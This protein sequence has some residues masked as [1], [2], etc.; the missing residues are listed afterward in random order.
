MA[1]NE[2]QALQYAH[3]GIDI[4]EKQ[5]KPNR[6]EF[7]R[8]MVRVKQL[9]QGYLSVGSVTD[10]TAVPAIQPNQALPE[11]D[12]AT[13]FERK[14]RYTKYGHMFR[15]DRDMTRA[16]VYKLLGDVLPKLKD[17]DRKRVEIQ[18]AGLMNFATGGDPN[19][20]TPDGLPIASSLHIVQGGVASN[21][22]AGNPVLSAAAVQQAIVE[23]MKVPTYT[24][25][26]M[27]I[28]GMVDLWVPPEL[29]PL[30]V[31]IKKTL[32]DVG[33]N[34]NDFNFA[35]S[36]IRNIVPSPYFTNS[37][38]WAVV[39][40]DVENPFLFLER[41]PL[42]TDTWEAKEFAEN[43]ASVTHAHGLAI[44]DWRAIRFS[45]GLGG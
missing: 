10:F 43:R 11:V 17:S 23:F 19:L 41:A 42:R 5:Y 34:N 18:V 20:V 14:Y 28:A 7:W 16:D 3:E 33:S 8:G 9:T 15:Y 37:K 13:P 4:V 26:P 12:Y 38:A 2:N 25:D 40:A 24:G 6:A 1:R 27:A 22:I 32:G 29:Y 21:I 45:T 36:R 39:S 30:A 35:G 31:I 44:K